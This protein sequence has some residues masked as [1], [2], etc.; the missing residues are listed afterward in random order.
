MIVISTKDYVINMPQVLYSPS[1]I[2]T[3]VKCSH[4]FSVIIISGHVTIGGSICME[5][6]TKSGWTPTNDIEV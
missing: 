5:M 6:L 3:K 1:F 4:K 2:F